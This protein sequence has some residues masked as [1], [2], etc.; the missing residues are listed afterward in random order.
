MVKRTE[1]GQF[2]PGFSGNPAG[3]PPGK[4]ALT[5]LLEI[6]GERAIT[7]K[8]RGSKEEIKVARKEVLSELAWELI[9]NGH[10][11]LMDGTKLKLPAQE[12]VSLYKW[13]FTHVDGPARA[14]LDIKSDGRMEIEVSY[15]EGSLTASDA[16]SEPA[17]D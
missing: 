16:A 11:V 10:V 17:E 1:K 8:P 7:L 4:R 2:A 14:E 6:A 3:R 12:W 5:K 9:L 15:V 13:I